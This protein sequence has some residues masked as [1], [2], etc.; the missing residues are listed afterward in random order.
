[1]RAEFSGLFRPFPDSFRQQTGN[2]VLHFRWFIKDVNDGLTSR[3]NPLGVYVNRDRNAS[4]SAF[5]APVRPRCSIS[6]CRSLR[7]SMKRNEVSW[8]E[9][10]SFHLYGK[11]QKSCRNQLVISNFKPPAI[12]RAIEESATDTSENFSFGGACW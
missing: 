8:I 3:R 1:M 7:R 12:Y 5:P 4:V 6:D 11:F 2:G 10:L 9:N